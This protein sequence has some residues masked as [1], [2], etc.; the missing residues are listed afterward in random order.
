VAESRE[1]LLDLLAVTG[2]TGNL[3]VSKDDD[4]EIFI[5]LCAMILEYGHSEISLLKHNFGSAIQEAAAKRPS[6]HTVA[7][8]PQSFKQP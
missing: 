4:L 7:V 3:I 8:A 6:L 1:E 2:G 5:A